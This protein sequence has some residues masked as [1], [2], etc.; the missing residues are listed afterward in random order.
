M[1]RLCTTLSH[2]E[3][4]TAMVTLP[5]LVVRVAGAWRRVEPPATMAA[6]TAATSPT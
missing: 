3:V 5:S 6:A 4:T 1:T 2:G